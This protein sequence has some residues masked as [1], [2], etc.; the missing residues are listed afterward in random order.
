MLS[1][2][3]STPSPFQNFSLEVV[4]DWFTPFILVVGGLHLILFIVLRIW[5][6]RDVRTIAQ[7][8]ERFTDGLHQRSRLD[9]NG[10]MTDQI[11]AFVQDVHD[12]LDDPEAR[13]LVRDRMKVLDEQRPYL[14]SYRFES[15]WNVA[16]SGIE[17]YP[18]LGVLGTI[19]ALWMAMRQ[20]GDDTAAAVGTIVERFG[21]AID[22]TFA[23]LAMAILLMVV[24]SAFETFFSRLNENRL[25]VRELIN[26]VKKEL[27]TDSSAAAENTP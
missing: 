4:S 23:G 12:A 26:H 1:N 20:T 9:W 22:S 21:L 6:G 3:T 15:I 24:N 14:N 18:L 10:H 17:A 25:S 2:A 13:T 27:I 19:L 16:R 5:A 8:L 7:L 11:D